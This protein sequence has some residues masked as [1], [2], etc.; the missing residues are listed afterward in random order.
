MPAGRNSQLRPDFDACDSCVEPPAKDGQEFPSNTFVIKTKGGK[1]A[2]H[3]TVRL[4]QQG[5]QNVLRANVV[6]I[7]LCGFV[8]R[9]LNGLLGPRRLRRLSNRRQSRPRLHISFCGHWN[10]V[11]VVDQPFQHMGRDATPLFEQPEQDM[12]GAY[13]FVTPLPGRPIGEKQHLFGTVGESRSDKGIGSR[14]AI[15]KGP[16]P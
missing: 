9:V 8:D 11:N 3:A 1:H 16:S 2:R 4:S 12:L 13:I 5:E 15:A 10:S 14:T 7:Q 6:V